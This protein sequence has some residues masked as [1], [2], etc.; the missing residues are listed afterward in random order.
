VLSCGQESFSSGSPQVNPGPGDVAVGPLII[1]NGR[2]LFNADTAP[3]YSW[4]SKSPFVVADG[5][6]VTVTVAGPAR[7][8]FVIDNPYADLAGIGAVTS[9]TYHA[10]THQDGNGFFAQGFAFT[11]GPVLGCVPLDVRIGDQPHVRHVTVTL[12]GRSCTH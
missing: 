5:A 12:A 1:V 2:R 11:H 7:G 6:T 8:R 10:C 9:A 4:S 3:Q